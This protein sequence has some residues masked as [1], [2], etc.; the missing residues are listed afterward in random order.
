MSR[1]NTEVRPRFGG[2]S[3]SCFPLGV[4]ACSERRG[5]GK[6]TRVKSI[7]GFLKLQRGDHAG[8]RKIDWRNIGAHAF[9]ASEHSFFQP[10]MPRGHKGVLSGEHFGT[11]K[12]KRFVALVGSSSCRQTARSGSSRRGQKNQ[13]KFSLRSHPG[14]LSDW[15]NR[16]RAMI[17]LIADFY[18][19][20]LECWSQAKR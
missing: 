12:E 13:F 8:R 1:K 14:G 7:L 18:K 3:A 17:S 16:S 15:L 9:A 2:M 6:T 5:A 11:F 4:S 19:V 10:W 20:L